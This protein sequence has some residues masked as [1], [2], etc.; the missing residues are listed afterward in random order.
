MVEPARGLFGGARGGTLYGVCYRWFLIVSARITLAG[1][2]KSWDHDF[3]SMADR[4]LVFD[5]ETRRRRGENS[6]GTV[7]DLFLL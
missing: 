7:A 5:E 6:A 4:R 1:R 3:R 2:R